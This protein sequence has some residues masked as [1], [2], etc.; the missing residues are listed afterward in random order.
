LMQSHGKTSSCAVT[1]GVTQGRLVG[2]VVKNR[3]DTRQIAISR[4]LGVCGAAVAGG[5][6][7]A[8]G[9]PRAVI[10][11][12]LGRS[13]KAWKINRLALRSRMCRT[14]GSRMDGNC[15]DGSASC[16]QIPSDQKS[17]GL[18]V[19]PPGGG[20]SGQPVA[21]GAPPNAASSFSRGVA[22]HRFTPP[23]MPPPFYVQAVEGA[24]MLVGGVG[25]GGRAS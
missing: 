12:G 18:I 1:Q 11:A 3:A 2:Y 19:F 16:G 25:V 4:V 8:A 24:R 13:R 20:S 17:L 10:G 21:T 7:A 5:A 15:A 9:A 22:P 6:G 14:A 23:A